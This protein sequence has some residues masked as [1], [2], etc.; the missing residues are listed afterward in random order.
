MALFAPKW[1][2]PPSSPSPRRSPPT[3]R[4]GGANRATA[5]AEVTSPRRLARAVAQ[6]PPPEEDEVALPGGGGGG[7]AGGAAALSPRPSSVGRLTPRTHLHHQ[8]RDSPALAAFYMRRGGG[9][10]GGGTNA[11]AK[12][13]SASGDAI[14]SQNGYLPSRGGS[15][16]RRQSLVNCDHGDPTTSRFDSG[17]AISPGGS[18]G[19]E[20]DGE[21]P[22]R[23]ESSEV[24]SEV[25]VE[26]GG[27]AE[28]GAAPEEAREDGREGAQ[29]PALPL[30][31]AAAAD[32]EGAC[33][34]REAP[35]PTGHLAPAA[36]FELFRRVDVEG[37]GT[38][39]L[40]QVERAAQLL[41]GGGEVHGPA[42]RRAFAAAE[43][44]ECGRIGRREFHLLLAQTANFAALFR[45]FGQ[46]GEVGA[47]AAALHQRLRLGREA[48]GRAAA[49]VGYPFATEHELRREFGAVL[50]GGTPSHEEGELGPVEEAAVEFG[51]FCHWMTARVR[52]ASRRRC[53]QAALH[54]PLP[55]ERAAQWRTQQ[56]EGERREALERRGRRRRGDGG[57][58]GA[59][60][61]PP[62]P[63]EASQGGGAVLA[64]RQGVALP[65]SR[66]E[67]DG[68]GR[69]RGGNLHR[70]P[71]AREPPPP[72]PWK[73]KH[74]PLSRGAQEDGD[75]TAFPQ[76]TAPSDMHRKVLAKAAAR[77][78]RPPSPPAV[79]GRPLY[80]SPS[81]E[82]RAR[83]ADL[84]RQAL[85]TGKV[86][87]PLGPASRSPA[88]GVAESTSPR[89]PPGWEQVELCNGK[90]YFVH[91]ASGRTS[92]THPTETARAQATEAVPRQSSSSSEDEEEEGSEEDLSDD[93]AVLGILRRLREG[94]RALRAAVAEA[95]EDTP[96]RGDAHVPKRR[97]R[98]GSGGAR[99]GP[100]LPG[101]SS[102]DDEEEESVQVHRQQHEKQRRLRALLA[103]L[104]S[105][106]L[107]LGAR[108]CAD[109]GEGG[110]GGGGSG[111]GGGGGET[112]G[113]G[114]GQGARPPSGIHERLYAQKRSRH[115]PLG[116][117]SEARLRKHGIDPAELRRKA[118]AAEAAERVRR[119]LRD[120]E[121]AAQ[122]EARRAQRR[123]LEEEKEAQL[124]AVQASVRAAAAASAAEVERRRAEAKTREVERRQY[125]LARL[126]ERRHLKRA[127]QEREQ[128]ELVHARQEHARWDALRVEREAE[129]AVEARRLAH[130]K[131]EAG[132]ERKR[133]QA[134]E[135]REEARHNH[136]Y[137]LQLQQDKEQEL[138]LTRQRSP[139][140]RGEK[141]LVT[142]IDAEEALQRTL[143]MAEEDRPVDGPF[144]TMI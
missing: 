29:P 91:L 115:N 57:A 102:E 36:A 103:E 96:R 22:A 128:R 3:A 64:L 47:G 56:R 82:P 63:R 54:S 33:P 104:D 8:P 74:A 86:K 14:R 100:L 42:L 68:H 116:H 7:G 113:E 67:Y 75:P 16:N 20:T 134:E 138:A 11:S 41:W 10:G 110:R 9:G 127:E 30:C 121:A 124:T 66:G 69:R 27:E 39:C 94:G 15:Q 118:E 2:G 55:Q 37:C 49:V 25:D 21:A 98:S 62:L 40:T 99:V 132:F 59:S 31:A 140:G 79:S 125:L 4:G 90:A 131:R 106:S 139:T 112:E 72:S 119:Q 89:L 23:T 78:Q 84:R 1:T 26:E 76:L 144:G 12:N 13:A 18:T 17:D 51:E 129:R 43:T 61:H 50:G 80:R 133:R 34:Q 88:T 19:S 95:A 52:E 137:H 93:D 32:E 141:Q 45:L 120:A 87:L 126:V 117:L 101:W 142:L 44:D 73:E 81:P 109:G 65:Q 122:R 85:D 6:P 35:L 5:G 143:S 24:G 58:E 48:F 38:L 135:A 105:P 123:L 107:A 130:E 70:R 136:Q 53:V 111:G 92:P 28:R 83:P 114:G 60:R 77:R 97:T 46:A 71:P 108:R